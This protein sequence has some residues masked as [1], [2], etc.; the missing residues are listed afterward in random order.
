MDPKPDFNNYL[1]DIIYDKDLVVGNKILTL[2]LEEA[3]KKNIFLR[4]EVKDLTVLLNTEIQ[5]S[6]HNF[7]TNTN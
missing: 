4:D 1:S 5:T 2:K 3:D 6:S 7:K